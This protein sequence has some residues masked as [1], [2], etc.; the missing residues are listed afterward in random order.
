[1]NFQAYISSYQMLSSLSRLSEMSGMST[2]DTVDNLLD[3]YTGNN[4]D[5]KATIMMYRDCRIS[6]AIYAHKDDLLKDVKVVYC[7]KCGDESRTPVLTT[8]QD[9]KTFRAMDALKLLV[10]WSGVPSEACDL[11]KKMLDCSRNVNLEFEYV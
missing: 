8:R 9:N 7:D 4:S 6:G 2:L 1:M 11:Q 10:E 5:K 3:P